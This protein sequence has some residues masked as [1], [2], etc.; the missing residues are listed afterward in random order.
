MVNDVL[1]EAE[2]RMKKTA[3]ALRHTLI[4]IRTGRASISLV[5]NMPVEAY[6]DL[7]PLNQ[8]A[9]ISTPD[10]RTIAIQPFDTSM[11]K[12]I[13]KSVKISDLGLNPNNDGRIIR[14]NLP[15]LNEERRKELVKQVR[16]RVEE[17]K[18]ALRNVRREALDDL[19]QLEN[20][21]MITEDD[22]RRGGE[23]LQEHMEKATRELEHIGANKEAEVLE[24]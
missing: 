17:S 10:A 15:P 4:S 12:A 8:L 1:R 3:E 6:D 7:L 16:T 23:K 14:L 13:E 20:E 24:I 2:S 18:V 22:Q 21:K 9:T 5:E 19:K 11:I